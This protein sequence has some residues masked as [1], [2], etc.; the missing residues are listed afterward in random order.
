MLKKTNGTDNNTAPGPSVTIGSTV[1][2]TYQVTN[3][4]NTTLTNIAVTDNRLSSSAIS[5]TGT[6]GGSN[7]IA[8]LAPTASATCTATGVAIAGQYTN[9]GT[10]TAG[11]VTA[12]DVDNYFGA[13]VNVSGSYPTATTCQQFIGNT[14][15]PQEDGQYSV[16]GKTISQGNPGVIFYY[17]RWT[18]LNATAYIDQ[19][20]LTAGFTRTMTVQS[21]T[22]YRASNCTAA[23]GT[24]TSPFL[25]TPPNDP[26]GIRLTGLTVGLE[27][28]VG[29]KYSVSSI[30]GA[31]PPAA[32]ANIVWQFQTRDNNFAIVA[33]DDNGFTLLKK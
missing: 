2:W 14:V 25:V 8:S 32:N 11:A 20:I 18:P 24:V 4:G 10:A 16:K 27:Y 13:G 19:Q 22:L 15:Q 30:V 21:V 31:T 7:V 29:V 3:S 6:P 1:T 5:C 17:S 9:T 28:V 12:S 33:K 26:N 23:P